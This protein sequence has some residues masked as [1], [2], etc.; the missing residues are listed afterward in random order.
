M[1]YLHIKKEKKNDERF[2]IPLTTQKH[3]CQKQQQQN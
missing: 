2:L 1:H 3:L